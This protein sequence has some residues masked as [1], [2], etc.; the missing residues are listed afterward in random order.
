V[1]KKL[2]VGLVVAF[3]L[4]YLIS[5]PAGAANAVKGAVDAVIAAFG[6]VGVFVNQLIQ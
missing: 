6:A 5:Q 3:V 1:V 2:A 4:Y